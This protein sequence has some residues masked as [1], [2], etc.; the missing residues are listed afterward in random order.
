[1]NLYGMTDTGLKRE[2]N[3]D[4]FY[5]HK[6]SEQVGFA[7]VCDGMGGQNAGHIASEMVCSVIS[8]RLIDSDIL[9]SS[10]DNISG[11]LISAISDANVQVYS[12]SNL[13]AGLKGM[14]TTAVI[15]IVVNEIAHIAHIGDSRAY[16]LKNAKLRQV[17]KDHSLVQELLEK[18]EI[19]ADEAINHPNKNMI[20]RAVGVNL[21][22]DIDYMTMKFGRG[23]KLLLC[24]DG[25]TNMVSNEVIEHVLNQSNAEMACKKLIE[26][27]NLA[28]GIDN[29]TIAII[30]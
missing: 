22:V 21:I 29:I 3:Q 16:L 20:T 14:G 2:M 1:M 24:S 27:S 4:V 18:G 10:H 23:S 15:C 19:S 6:F 7:I 11:L 17:T 30:E 28:G 26:L 8:S 13:E 5:T 25:L 12:R 9:K